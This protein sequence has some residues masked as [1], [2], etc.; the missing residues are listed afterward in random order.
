MQ[1]WDELAEDASDRHV[2]VGSTTSVTRWRQKGMRRLIHALQPSG[3]VAFKRD[4]DAQRARYLVVVAFESAAD[5][6]AL[7]QAV[8]AEPVAE[9]AGFASQRGFALDGTTTR[10]VR[11]SLKRL[12]ATKRLLPTDQ[13]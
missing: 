9:Y 13:A 2:V 5:A 8:G 6:E 7:A 4:F 10:R 1:N 11:A 12:A 3:R